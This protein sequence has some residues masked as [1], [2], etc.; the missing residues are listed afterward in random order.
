MARHVKIT[1]VIENKKVVAWECQ[2]QR[3]KWVMD[4][5]TFCKEKGWTFDVYTPAKQGEGLS[6]Y[7]ARL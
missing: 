2:G 5:F 4:A 6:E 1:P 7:L 3:F